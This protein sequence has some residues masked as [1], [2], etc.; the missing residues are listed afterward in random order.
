M[1]QGHG[2]Q[3]EH[4]IAER[5]KKSKALATSHQGEGFP[6]EWN[7]KCIN[8]EVSIHFGVSRNS[9]EAGGVK[10]KE[11]GQQ[12]LAEF[13]FAETEPGDVRP[14]RSRKEPAAVLI[15]TDGP[16]RVLNWRVLGEI[17]ISAGCA[18]GS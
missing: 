4:D 17:D 7:S 9:Q 13:E 10:Q 2:H 11:E 12:L 18:R 8:P 6:G 15:M 5:L 16:L 3:E 14:C 1:V